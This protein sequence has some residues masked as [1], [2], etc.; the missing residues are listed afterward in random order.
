MRILLDM[1]LPPRWVEFLQDSGFEAK[2]WSDI[3]DIRAPDEE[4]MAWARDNEYVVFTHDLDFS[5]LLARTRASG[6]SVLQL[7]AQDI[8][9]EAVGQQVLRVLARHRESL[10]EGAIVSVD[11]RRSRVRVLPLST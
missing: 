11:A 2:H 7:R 4:V 8:V 9:P 10:V 1:N 6:P 3:G 5:A